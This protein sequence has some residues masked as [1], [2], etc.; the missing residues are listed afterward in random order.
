MVEV[1]PT[2][3]KNNKQEQRNEPEIMQL[4]RRPQ[5]PQSQAHV[6]SQTHMMYLNP[7]FSLPMRF[8]T[9]T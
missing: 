9:G 5:V 7:W 8:S 1:V 2:I 6:H 3:E 4:S